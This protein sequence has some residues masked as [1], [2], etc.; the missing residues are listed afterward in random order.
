M[1]SILMQA[2]DA[3]AAIELPKI[4][5]ALAVTMKSTCRTC[6]SALTLEEMHYYDH[7]DGSA[8]C[9]RCEGKWMA[10]MAEWKSG[11]CGGEM[12]SRP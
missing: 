1:W 4:E 11:R 9:N 12:P 10:E 7:G 3:A 2:V 5:G 6:G 8:T